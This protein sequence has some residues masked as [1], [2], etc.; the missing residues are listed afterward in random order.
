MHTANGTLQSR[1][2][3][4]CGS[5]C[6][7]IISGL[8]TETHVTSAILTRSVAMG[9]KDPSFVTPFVKSLIKKYNRLLRSA[10][11]TQAETLPSELTPLL[12]KDVARL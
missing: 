5:L 7:L 12:L 8:T 4:N 6:C 1:S 11:L 10:R 3:G 9:M 2:S